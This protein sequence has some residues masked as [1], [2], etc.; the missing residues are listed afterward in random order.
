M[1]KLVALASTAA[2]IALVGCGADTKSCSTSPA[3]L[4]AGSPV[5][6]C[7]VAPGGTA[8]IQV[9]L[10]PKCTD[11]SPSCIAEFRNNAIEIDPIFRECQEDRSCP[12]GGSCETDP[13]KTRVFC[14]VTIPAG[15]ASGTYDVILAS[16]AT[17]VSSVTVGASGG[18]TFAVA[19]D[20]TAAP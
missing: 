6:R 9:Q 4:A 16:T 20:A 18:C 17:S 7:S 8:N 1:K 10:C 11:S 12:I 5:Q 14:S 2:A 15:T 13:S 3:T 19:G